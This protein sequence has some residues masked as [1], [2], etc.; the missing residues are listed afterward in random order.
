M[1]SL[2]CALIG[3]LAGGAVGVEV[4]RRLMLARVK[5]MFIGGRL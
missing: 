3:A 2:F 1:I 4:G 5:Q